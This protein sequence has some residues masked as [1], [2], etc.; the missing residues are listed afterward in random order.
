MT[1]QVVA[2]NKK[3]DTERLLDE[4]DAAKAR[5]VAAIESGHWDV[6]DARQVVRTHDRW[7]ASFT[8]RPHGD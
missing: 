1:A 4:F 5:L 6:E 7:V 3:V 2:I 8:E